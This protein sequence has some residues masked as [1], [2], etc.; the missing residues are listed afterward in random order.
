MKKLLLA[1]MATVL[2]V[3]SFAQQHD[4]VGGGTL[5]NLTGGFVSQS[6]VAPPVTYRNLLD[7]GAFNVYQR[8]TTA[9][10][11][12]NTTATYH[13]DRWAGFSNNASASVTLS[14]ATIN[15]PL[16]FSN[17][18]Q[19]QRANGN[20]QVTPL[21]LA[22]E[23][24]TT[25]VIALQGQSVCLSAY[26]LAGANFSAASSKLT[27]QVITGTGTD[28]GLAAL[29]A[30]TWTGQATTLSDS[31]Q[32]LQTY[33]QRFT[34]SSW[35]FT[36]PATATEAAVEVGFTPTGTAGAADLIQVTGLQFEEMPVLPGVGNLAVQSVF[37]QRP[38]G[39]ETVKAQRYFFQLNESNSY[40][41][42]NAQCSATN[43]VTAAIATPVQM[44]TT[45]TV[46]V[47]AGGFQVVIAG[48]AATAVTTLAAGTS[49][50]NTVVVTTA[51]TCTAGGAVLVRGSG[52]TGKITATA[53]F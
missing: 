38:V 3:S 15:L 12:V 46:G 28:Q 42:F 10:T 2:A 9:V 37:E 26:A 8:G 36:M 45:P 23:I 16:G 22:Q 17:A 13:A 24:P 51:N 48:A 32:S 27:V 1:F 44:R 11:G 18:E 30:G 33:V 49:N 39:F 47:T 31:S 7:N 29:I 20:T 35:C 41:G 4:N 21:Y 52:T 19:L 14:N 6:L 40:Y 50:P 25:D 53:D 43:V 34:P 5:L